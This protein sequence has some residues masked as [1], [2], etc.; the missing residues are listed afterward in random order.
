MTNTCNGATCGSGVI[1]SHPPVG[2]TPQP[3]VDAGRTGGVT[4][5]GTIIVGNRACT[6]QFG[7]TLCLTTPSCPNVVIDPSQF[8][9]CGF[10]A[11]STAFSVVCICNGTLL[12]P[13]GA[14]ATCDQLPT[15]LQQRTVADIC[16]QVTVEGA[17]QDI[18]GAGVVVG[19]DLNCVATCANSPVCIAAC[20][21]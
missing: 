7:V 2:G 19:C 20:G 5:G 12:C 17:C 13:M 14:V 18:T 15:L 10:R 9:A 11:T 4:P 3:G 8:P 21:C 16:N 1:P 6:T